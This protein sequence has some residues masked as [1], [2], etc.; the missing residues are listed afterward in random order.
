[1]RGSTTPVELSSSARVTDT[2]DVVG[3]QKTLGSS[4]VPLINK[5]QDI[6]AS[7]GL[8]ELSDI[9]LPQIAVV[10][11]Q[12]SGKSSVLEALVG[13]D[14]LPRGPEICTRRPLLLQLVH[15]PTNPRSN[16]PSEWG[17]F[18]HRPGERFTD[19]EEIRREIDQETNRVTGTNKAV[20]DQQ[21]R[22]KIC[23][24]NVLTMTLVDLPGITRV[25]VG[26]QPKDIEKQIRNMILSYIKRD[27]CLILAV[28]PANSD[29]A[30]SDALTLAQ[31]V[32]PEG[33][34]TIGVITKLDI[35]DRG[36]D[37]RAYLKN[38]V[39]PLKLGY[40]G[41][42]NRCQ[43]DIAGKVSMEKARN[44][45]GDFFQSR[46]EYA[47]IIGRCGMKAL[48]NTVSRLLSEHV[49]RLLPDLHRSVSKRRD[50]AACDVAEFGECVPDSDSAQ[51]SVVLQKIHTFCNA[52]D[53]AVQ[54]K[55]KNLA[56]DSLEGGARV[57]Y[58]L[59]E[60]F[61]K[62]LC[63]L[64]PTYQLSEEDIRT[65]IQNAAGTKAVLL[66][67][68]EPFEILARKAIEKMSDPCHQ[69]A[70]LVYDELNT[71][72][73]NCVRREVS[74]QFPKLAEAIEEATREFLK[75]GLDPAESMITNLV[76][77]QLAHINTTH[78]D[79]IGGARALGVAQSQLEKRRA[80]ERAFSEQQQQ[81]REEMEMSENGVEEDAHETPTKK[82]ANTMKSPLKMKNLSELN[83]NHGEY[84]RADS[85]NEA[86]AHF[87]DKENGASEP[88]ISW[89]SKGL[90][91]GNGNT[92]KKPQDAGSKGTKTKRRN[93]S[94][95]QSIQDLNASDHFNH[96]SFGVV[97]LMSPP[98]ILLPSEIDNDEELLQVLVTRT[99][100]SSYFKLTRSVLADMVP[101]AIMHFLVN[102]IARGLQQHLISTLYHPSTVKQLLAEDPDSARMRRNATDRLAALNKAMS[103]ISAFHAELV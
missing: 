34:R 64:D 41:V 15:T 93:D 85:S 40:I 47:E 96:T 92:P 61:V 68:E 48:G 94:L 72:T 54:G 58:V 102:S 16:A 30:N 12:S 55:S 49:A 52:V 4:L 22:L 18:L 27:S 42:V 66:L 26:D 33:L 11:S 90:W 17:E 46:K 19:F 100:L 43:A 39:V 87:D 7:A 103:A 6:F 74:K 63:S 77:C 37:A 62:G 1:M 38:E 101:K 36:T 86:S 88:K 53:G 75:N 2:T 25:P 78:P 76:D 35:M 14:F 89:I 82:K 83:N 57:H 65:A 10:G 97:S 3:A 21:I 95:R 71:L 73:S 5:L 67:P 8:E 69:A 91:G 81:K 32:D 60:I 59:Q 29:L 45:E 99:L 84:N 44:A 56:T 51:A 98:G 79:F 24:P 9:D 70:K 23:S 80:K 50:K 31:L 20:S 28:S 13:R